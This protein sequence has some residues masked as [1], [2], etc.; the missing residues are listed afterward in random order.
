MKIIS[1]VSMFDVLEGEAKTNYHFARTV[2]E[3]TE[4]QFSQTSQVSL[5][6]VI[7]RSRIMN[8]I[9]NSHERSVGNDMWVKRAFY[10]VQTGK[11]H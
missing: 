8:N 1:Y 2:A 11:Y 4:S 6:R 7:N 10:S 9:E 5:P 3:L